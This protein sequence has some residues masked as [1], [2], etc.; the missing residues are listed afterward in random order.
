ML[1]DRYKLYNENYWTT[2][3]DVRIQHKKGEMLI[4][5][6]RQNLI[7]LAS[8]T[9]LQLE[10]D[11]LAE[12]RLPSSGIQNIENLLVMPHNLAEA[13]TYE[14]LET[15]ADRKSESYNTVILF[16]TSQMFLRKRL[17]Q[18]QR[19]LYGSDCLNQP[20][21]EVGAILHGHE[22]VLDGWR[23]MLPPG[24]RWADDDP[25]PGDTL[26][27]R[28]RAK[29][30]GARYVINRPFLDYALHIMPHVKD[31]QSVEEAALDVHHNPRNQAEIH[32]F[33]AIKQL[34]EGAIL[35]ACERCIE[36]AMQSTVAFDGVP[37]R[38]VVTNIHGT[39][40]A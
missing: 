31:G 21:D 39:A 18:V 27:A 8:W 9:C 13:E 4:A 14:G 26:S 34:G 2:F 24:L 35:S 3:R 12:I 16:Y 29:Y 38:L 7:V 5:D 22:A 1:L 28:L 10:S 36:A 20:L 19:Q 17:N 23:V 6:M 11:I 25:P 30:W 40:H 33:N 32:L 15:H 37:D